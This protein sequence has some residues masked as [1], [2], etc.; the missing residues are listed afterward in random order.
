DRLEALDEAIRTYLAWNSIVAEKDAL[1]LTHSQVEQAQTQRRNADTTIEGRLAEAYN[2][3]LA[4]AQ[5]DPKG[6]LEWQAQRL[7]GQDPLAVRAS[8]RLTN[9]D[10]LVPKLAPSALRLEID[11]VP[12][13]R[14]DHVAIRQ[15]IED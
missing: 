13:W 4:P 11:K 1:D 15:L 14:G 3:L 2:W 7:M 5:A 9:D 10:L 8:K 12:L 6:T